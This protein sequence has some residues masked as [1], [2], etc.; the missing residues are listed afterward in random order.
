MHSDTAGLIILSGI[1]L[2]A[3]YGGYDL[4]KRAWRMFVKKKDQSCGIIRSYKT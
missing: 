4:F 2:L 1:I 3:I